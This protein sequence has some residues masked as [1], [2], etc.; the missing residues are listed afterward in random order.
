MGFGDKFKDLAKQAKE[1][2]A[3]HQEQIHGAVDAAAA[4]ADQKTNRKYSDK[5]A[6]LGQ[7]AGEAVDRAAGQPATGPGGSAQPGTGPG[8]PGPSRPDSSGGPEK[9]SV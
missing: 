4:A 3:E 8:G 7:K 9:P 2:V 5:I 1:T 6:K